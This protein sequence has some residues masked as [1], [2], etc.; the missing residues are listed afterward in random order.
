M[1]VWVCGGSMGE[2][3]CVEEVMVCGGCKG[4]MME[5]KGPVVEAILC[6]G[7]SEYGGYTRKCRR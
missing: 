5:I 4:T 7:G 6:A 3:G 2:N 1:E